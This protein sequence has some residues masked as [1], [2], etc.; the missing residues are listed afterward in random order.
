MGRIEPE[1]QCQPQRDDVV[2]THWHAARLM[3]ALTDPLMLC[4]IT[5]SHRRNPGGND[6][7]FRAVV[8][9][10]GLMA[11]EA[12]L[13][14]PQ[15]ALDELVAAVVGL[16]GVAAVCELVPDP[17]GDGGAGGCAGAIARVRGA[18]GVQRSHAGHRDRGAGGSCR[19]GDSREAPD[20]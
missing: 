1:I 16:A 5:E 2:N 3:S 9:A 8:R 15:L 6:L 18:G 4:V 12:D 19:R 7:V 11:N 14:E 13:A 10:A 20:P 17:G